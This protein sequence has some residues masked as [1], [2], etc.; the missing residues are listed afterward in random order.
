MAHVRLFNMSSNIL[1]KSNYI[2]IKFPHSKR[3]SV[4]ANTTNGKTIRR[5][6]CNN[7]ET[8][9]IFV[10]LGKAGGGS[11]RARIAASSHNFT[12]ERW[13]QTDFSYYNVVDKDSNQRRQNVTKAYFCNS[14]NHNARP[15]SAH[16]QKRKHVHTYEGE[17]SCYAKTPI[18]RS[19][20]CSGMRQRSK[21]TGAEYPKAPVVY[22]GHNFIGSEMHWLPVRY[23]QNWWGHFWESMNEDIIGP[24]EHLFGSMTDLPCQKIGT[25]FNPYSYEKCSAST[26]KIVDEYASQWLSWVANNK[27]ADE[28][29]T[30]GP[31]V[32]SWAPVYASLP[33]LRAVQ[34]REPFSW[35]VS[36]YFW[37]KISENYHVSC[38]NI[39][40]AT[41]PPAL[42]GNS[43]LSHTY[44]R[45]DGWLRTFSL[46]YIFYLC[47]ED[48]MSRFQSNATS[49]DDLERQAKENLRHSFAVVGL[50][51]E[52]ETFLNMISARVQYIDT[53]RNK[54]VKGSTHKQ[55]KSEYCE[56][57]YQTKSFQE[58]IITKAPELASLVRLFELGERVNRFQLEELRQCDSTL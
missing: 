29:Y 7:T 39:E 44:K 40:A 32:S 47:G 24:I 30:S 1:E 38:D 35:L 49:L 12:G 11:V 51:N 18:G 54:H 22:V 36:K 2:P 52:T 10:H 31:S 9:F 15:A 57:L 46:E 45:T 20:A 48:C 34:I 4:R 27:F 8:P 33:L 43:H 3:I 6:G 58:K 14:G 56:D 13:Y 21:C 5:W 55:P 25:K 17:L 23:L 53:N 26:H 37:H 16:K 19:I 50:V 41:K 28:D 42:F